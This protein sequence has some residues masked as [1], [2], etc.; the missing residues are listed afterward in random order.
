MENSGID[1][2]LNEFSVIK[3]SNYVQNK[4]FYCI[5]EALRAEIKKLKIQ[6]KN[7]DI[8]Q[9]D[10][11]IELKTQNIEFKSQINNLGLGVCLVK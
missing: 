10:E 6:I 11:I 5:I 7:N 3:G 2:R 9:Q 8:K 1:I 4:E